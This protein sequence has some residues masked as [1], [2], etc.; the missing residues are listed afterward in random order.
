MDTQTLIT[1]LYILIATLIMVSIC[2]LIHSARPLIHTLWMNAMHA[3]SVQRFYWRQ[4]NTPQMVVSS[5]VIAAATE[6]TFA[7]GINEIY[8]GYCRDH[9]PRG[10]NEG[11]HAHMDGTRDICMFEVQGEARTEWV[12]AHELA[13]LIAK[14]KFASCRHD[15]T[16]KN[17]MLA[18]GYG[19]DA[20]RYAGEV[21]SALD[22]SVFQTRNPVMARLTAAVDAEVDRRR[23]NI[24][25]WQIK[26][27]TAR[28]T[29]PAA[30]AR[31]QSS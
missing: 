26:K 23:P 22:V 19:E 21:P 9:L 16:W 14:A 3:M 8:V 1:A 7:S 12:L 31:T 4:E 20:S 18:I 29:S 17:I 27:I 5:R 11:A 10:T 25:L 30:A 2:G 6:N 24:A 15:K 13:H 28:I